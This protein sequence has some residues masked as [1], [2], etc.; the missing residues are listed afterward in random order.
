MMKIASRRTTTQLPIGS[1][2]K[3]SILLLHL[4]IL[5]IE[6]GHTSKPSHLGQTL[7]RDIVS[8]LME[9]FAL[10]ANGLSLAFFAFHAGSDN[11]LY[12]SHP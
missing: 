4:K 5:F 10:S 8:S 7:A 3:R 9:T 2:L 1:T 6:T 11:V 12:P